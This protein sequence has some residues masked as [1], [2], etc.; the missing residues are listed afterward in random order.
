MTTHRRDTSSILPVLVLIA[1]L[2]C[3]LASGISYLM[4]PSRV[5]I[6]IGILA[7]GVLLALAAVFIAPKMLKEILTSRTSWL[8]VNDV[9][10]V[11]VIIGIGVL[12]S[13]IGFRRHIRYD[14]TRD[15]L[16]SISDST[17]KTL[18]GLQKD[19]KV[20]A[21]Y[22][23]GSLEYTM[24]DDLLREYRRNTD[25]LVV[26]L[27]DPFRDPMTTKAMNV[28]TAGTVVVQCENQRKDIPAEELFLRPPPFA[29]TR[30]PPKFQGEQAITSAILNVTSGVR[31]KVAFVKGHGEPGLAS[32]KPDGLAATQQF[33]AR[34]NYE[35]TEVS[36]LEGIST[37]TT[38]LALIAPSQG[39]HPDEIKALRQYVNER[40]GNLLV[41]L[42][43]DN[44]AAELEQFLGDQF[45]LT[46]NSEIIISP[47][48]MNGDL[49]IVIPRYSSHPIVKD[50]ME[51]NSAVLM[52]VARGLNF[53]P[54]DTYTGL[55]FL[56]TDENCY[57]KRPPSAV[58]QGQ[59]Q[60][61]QNTDVRGPLNLGVA[62]E[63]KGTA[64]GSR[65]VVFGDADFATNMLLQVQ[66]NADLVVNTI[67]WLAGQEQL[68]S[69]R[70]KQIQ[71]AQIILDAEAAQ[72]I[73]VLCVVV[74]PLLIVLLGGAVWWSR[75]RV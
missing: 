54:R 4:F 74:S 7:A 61:D 42:N 30:E 17:I 29:Q 6:A 14:F 31:R 21:F 60:F 70:P 44:K 45:G 18:R 23:L 75:R 27:V 51:K 33:L 15:S 10:L 68:I 53:E 59:I 1:G 3:V 20:T 9:V 64:S 67:N 50:L 24:L 13:Y 41:A 62:F 47:R 46:C 26:K 35:T 56:R 65:A 11:V 8:I 16:F 40:K 43:P 57:G 5:N 22:P 32:F 39:F 69:I 72:R 36:L 73:L 34:E 52:Q 55:A 48:G 63:G 71:I 66:G 37:D 49:S 38:V 12:L 28:H 25:R 2:L 58:L 19:V